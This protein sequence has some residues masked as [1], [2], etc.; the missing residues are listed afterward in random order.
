MKLGTRDPC[1]RAVQARLRRQA[2]LDRDGT[3]PHL[4]AIITEASPRYHGGSVGERREQIE[5]LIEAARRP[6]V[7]LRVL[8]FADGFHPGTQG[9]INVFTVPCPDEPPMLNLETETSLTEVRPPDH[10]Y[11]PTPSPRRHPRRSYDL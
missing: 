3:A 8:R 7:E 11:R 10:P 6:N 9:M 5:R 4:I 2:I 1:E